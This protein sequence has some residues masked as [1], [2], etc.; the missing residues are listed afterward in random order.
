VVSSSPFSFITLE[1]SKY[2]QDGTE[3]ALKVALMSADKVKNG[4]TTLNRPTTKS[5]KHKHVTT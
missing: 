3:R 4:N 1:L 5:T 2:E